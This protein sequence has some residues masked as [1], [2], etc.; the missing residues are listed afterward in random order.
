M[1]THGYVRPVVLA[2]PLQ[3]PAGALIHDT[4]TAAVSGATPAPCYPHHS[5]RVTLYGFKHPNKIHID[6]L[7]C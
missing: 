5:V 7:G 3:Q 1:Q 4:C 2:T 6:T